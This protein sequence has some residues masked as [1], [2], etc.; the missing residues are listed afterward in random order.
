[1][2]SV[3]L[4]YVDFSTW[5]CSKPADEYIGVTS[6]TSRC[7]I[8]A[9]L[10]ETRG[11]HWMVFGDGCWQDGA[12]VYHY[13]SVLRQFIID[14]DGLGQQDS[15]TGEVRVTVMQCVRVLSFIIAQNL[16]IEGYA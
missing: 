6:D 12:R 7:P 10:K 11:G 14:I 15:E 8:A 9:W 3:L 13:D 2:K 16:G 1:M 5:L 4:Q